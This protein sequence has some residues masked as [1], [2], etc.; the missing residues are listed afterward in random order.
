ME[1][2]EGITYNAKGEAIAFSGH[3]AVHCY[4]AA[5]L[6]GAL[7]LLQNGIKPGRGWTLTR[8]LAMASQYTGKAYKRTQATQAREDLSIWIQTMK[9]ALPMEVANGN[10]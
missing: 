8:A 2:K 1:I 3:D 4:R 6:R 7:Y 5:V 9:A 10:K